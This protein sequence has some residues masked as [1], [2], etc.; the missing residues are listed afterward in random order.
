MFKRKP[1]YKVTWESERKA[2]RL[3]LFIRV[4]NAITAANVRLFAQANKREG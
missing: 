3:P 4:R 1:R 2:P